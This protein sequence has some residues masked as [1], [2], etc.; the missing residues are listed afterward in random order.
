[1]VA[2]FLEIGAHFADC[3]REFNFPAAHVIIAWIGSLDSVHEAPFS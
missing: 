2:R 3:C 1:M